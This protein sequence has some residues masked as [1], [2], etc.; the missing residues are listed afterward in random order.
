MKSNSGF[1]AICLCSRGDVD[2]PETVHVTQRDDLGT[3]VVQDGGKRRVLNAVG[4]DHLRTF[5]QFHPIS[6]ILASESEQG[7]C[8]EGCQSFK[9]HSTT[10][11]LSVSVWKSGTSVGQASFRAAEP[12]R[13]GEQ[14]QFGIGCQRPGRGE[15]ECPRAL[16][17]GTQPAPRA[18]VSDADA[19]EGCR[20][21][22]W[23]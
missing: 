21:R 5:G 17:V 8:Q 13:I 19:A 10:R 22:N 23:G 16:L 6:R 3:V 7:H 9:R 4:I 15:E 1:S 20:C 12:L 2:H 11:A 18:A 14:D